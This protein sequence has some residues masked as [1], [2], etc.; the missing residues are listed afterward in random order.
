MNNVL[1][2]LQHY[3]DVI[4]NIRQLVQALSTY[5]ESV[6]S[7]GR[8]L[9]QTQIAVQH[10]EEKLDSNRKT[11]ENKE[12]Y[13][14]LCKEN[15]EKFEHDLMEVT[16]QKEYS[17]VLKE[18][19]NTKKEIQETETAIV[20]LMENTNE[21]ESNLEKL[22]AAEAQLAK[23]HGDAVSGFNETNKEK[24]KEKAHYEELQKKLQAS[25]PASYMRRFTQI[26][27][28]RGGI[29]VA[30]VVGD[31][32]S[33]CNMKIRPQMVNDMKRVP[34]KLYTCDNCQRILVIDPDNDDNS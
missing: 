8:Q 19:D 15:L 17:A 11:L 4:F 23:E 16:N 9:K 22:K 3:Q 6:E 7:L 24:V 2:D 32:C 34:D 13:L 27:A 29:A 1:H 25:I 18:I 14:T 30:R 28:K 10:A 20:T 21:L 26:A 31:C 5:P 12:S 33:A